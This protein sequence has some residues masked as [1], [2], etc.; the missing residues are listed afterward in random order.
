MSRTC[1]RCFN[2]TFADKTVT[3]CLGNEHFTL[4]LCV[5]H[6]DLF[7]L[8]MRSWTLVA[9]QGP[10]VHAPEPVAARTQRAAPQPRRQLAIEDKSDLPV[11]SMREARRALIAAQAAAAE[12]AA[13]PILVRVEQGQVDAR[14]LESKTMA[15]RAASSG[16]HLSTHAI[17]RAVE[18]EIPVVQAMEAAYDPVFT[19]PARNGLRW[20]YRNGMRVCIDTNTL[21]IVTVCRPNEEDPS[22]YKRKVAA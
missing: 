13:A 10:G 7:E 8:D 4:N 2:P 19:K 20:H 12:A 3:F 18:R 22:V 6:A 15:D 16:Y 17:E 21:T 14:M 9:Q 11:M 1:V 5:A